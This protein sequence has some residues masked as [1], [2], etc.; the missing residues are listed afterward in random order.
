MLHKANPN[1]RISMLRVF[2]FSH[3]FLSP[4]T[5]FTSKKLETKSATR[6]FLWSTQRTTFLSAVTRCCAKGDDLLGRPLRNHS[7][8][9]AGEYVQGKNRNIMHT[10]V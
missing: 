2:C 4:E 6:I 7:P 3:S 5:K 10:Q 8:Y 9:V 1:Q